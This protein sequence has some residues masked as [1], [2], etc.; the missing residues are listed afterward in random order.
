MT[1]SASKRPAVAGRRLVLLLGITVNASHAAAQPSADEDA[2]TD[3]SRFDTR[4]LTLAGQV[5]LASP[6]GLLGVELEYGLQRWLAVGAGVGPT[7]MGGADGTGFQAG[8][9]LA[10]RLAFTSVAVGLDLGAS[11]GPY[12]DSRF[13]DEHSPWAKYDSAGWFNAA[14]RFQYLHRRGFSLRA[15]LG[16]A[17]LLNPHAGDCGDGYETTQ[18]DGIVLAYGGV[19][20][21]YAFAR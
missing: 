9:W 11:L 5:G 3:V 2:A 14:A 13:M 21:G 18:C 6:G 20:F 17:T 15:F 12:S 4:P 16:A 8:A 10:P 19:S 1:C 7:V